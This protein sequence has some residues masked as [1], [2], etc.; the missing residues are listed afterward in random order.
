MAAHSDSG[1]LGASKRATRGS[2]SAAL[3]LVSIQAAWQARVRHSLPYRA[4]SALRAALYAKIAPF[5]ETS[6]AIKLAPY[7]SLV[8]ACLLLLVSPYVGT[9]LNALMVLLAFGTF[10][11]QW[12]VEKPVAKEADGLDLPFLALLAVSI[13]AVGFSPYLVLSVKGLAKML[14]FWMSFLAFRGALRRGERG[15]LPL[16]GAL[17]VAAFAQSLYGI[18]QWKIQVA[19]LALWD[20]SEAEVKLTRVYGTLLNPNLLSGYL[21]PIIPF[22]AAAA[23]TWKAWGMRLLAVGTALTAPI[24][25]YFTYSRGAYLGLVG[26]AV[27]FGVL[28]FAALWPAIRRRPWLLGVLAGLLA[29]GAVG[30]VVAYHHSPAMQER[31]LS[32]TATRTHSSN[33]FRMNVWDGVIR[34]I[35][36]SWWFGIG[37]GNDAF[38]KVY[39]LYMVSGFEALGAYNIFL[40]E[41]VEKGIFGLLAFVALVGGGIFRALHHFKQG[42]SRPWATAAIASLVGLMIHGMV[43]TVFY[44]PSVQILF[45]LTLAVILHLPNREQGAA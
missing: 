3:G 5:A 33:S 25:L 8:A 36:H 2:L 41:L 45:W 23:M 28:G 1:A 16:F 35:E 44:R 7:F 24:C 14:V 11:F 17:F 37:L 18:Y 12:V 43:D 13:V 26:E 29:L 19:P 15:W 9:G 38:R 34:M 21:I 6:L 10:L 39:A 31:L 32:I 30:A 27:V 40:E 42:V 4:T 22:A 20:D